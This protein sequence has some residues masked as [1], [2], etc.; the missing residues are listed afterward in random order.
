M[1]RRPR[2]PGSRRSRPTP[3]ADSP[4]GLV[5]GQCGTLGGR[6]RA[7]VLPSGHGDG[8]PARG[9]VAGRGGEV[10]PDGPPAGPLQRLSGSGRREDGGP[11]SRLAG[12]PPSP[13]RSVR[14]FLFPS[15][16]RRTARL[17]RWRP[18]VGCSSAGRAP[19]ARDG[20][21]LPPPDRP[22]GG[23]GSESRRPGSPGP[24]VPPVPGLRVGLGGGRGGRHPFPA[25]ASRGLAPRSHRAG[26]P[27]CGAAG[28]RSPSVRRFRGCGTAR[29][30]KPPRKRCSLPPR[31]HP[32]LL[33]G[34]APG[35]P[36]PV[37]AVRF[38]V[39]F[40]SPAEAGPAP[41]GSGGTARE[42]GPRRKGPGSRTGSSIRRKR[43][44]N[45]SVYAHRCLYFLRHTLGASPS[46]DRDR[47]EVRR[48]SRPAR[49][50]PARKH[51]RLAD[52]RA[53][54]P[55]VTRDPRRPASVRDRS[56]RRGRTVRVPPAPEVHRVPP[57]RVIWR[58]RGRVWRWERGP[59]GRSG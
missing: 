24:P 25:T 8:R 43:D 7:P 51:R 36:A 56:G 52:R 49:P 19:S 30:G 11:E 2:S 9:R 35:S 44:R 59:A 4:S 14:S 58:G 31:W 45:G 23:R 15:R 3:T 57:W 13:A 46:P 47:H 55:A 34:R 37:P 40:R 53:P 39:P 54:S 27:P 21:R 22:P 50:A 41:G 5:R 26:S 48:S 12:R 33:R 1:S 16:R 29:S 28:L 38:S 10:A 17:P 42:I 6:K 20:S 18:V 32:P